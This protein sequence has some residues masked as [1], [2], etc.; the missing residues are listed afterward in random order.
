LLVA[1][2]KGAASKQ[3]ARS[4]PPEVER[5]QSEGASPLRAWREFRCFSQAQLAALTGI[6]RAYLTQIET[7]GRVGTIEVM[8]RLADNLGCL[9]EQLIRGRGDEFAAKLAALARMPAQLMDVVRAL[10][11]S[12][13]TMKPKPDEF[14]L[15]EHVCHLRDIDHDGYRERIERMLAEDRPELHD[16]DG[17]ALAARRE[18]QRQDLNAACAAF[19]ETRA[20]IVDRLR[21]LSAQARRRTGCMK[22]AGDMTIDDLIDAMLAHDSGHRDELGELCRSLQGG[23]DESHS[24]TGSRT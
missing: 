2:A 14:S 9:I 15:L 3:V 13:W 12:A 16:I 23:L 1:A 19:T 18:Y 8:A 5:R 11:R 24:V 20:R 22:G 7:G 6:S 21:D 4:L 10:P 17:T